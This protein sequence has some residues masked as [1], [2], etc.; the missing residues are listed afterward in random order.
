[1]QR[2]GRDRVFTGALFNEA[3]QLRSPKIETKTLDWNV[4]GCALLGSAP[5][6]VLN[7]GSSDVAVTEQF[8]HIPNVDAG[9]EQQGS[10]GR[11]QGMRAVETRTFLD[12]P[13]QLRHVA[14]NDSVHAGLAHGLVTKLIAVGRAPSPENRPSRKSSF[15][16]VFGKRLGRS[17]MDADGAV[18]VAFLVDGE[19]GLV[20]VLMKVPH[21]QP[22]GGGK[23]DAGVEVGFEDGAVA[24]IEHVRRIREVDGQPQFGGGASQVLVEAGGREDAGY[25]AD[26]WNFI[27]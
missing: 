1:M 24:E 17:E 19:G 13:R 9:I 7:L 2:S 14:C 22:A 11:P 25:Q 8:L 12:R 10:G 23:P 21:A 16:K 18:A 4:M 26:S 3:E 5:S 27:R 20:A 15:P 6:F